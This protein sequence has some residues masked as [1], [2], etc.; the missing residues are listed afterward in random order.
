M[1]R[2][3]RR[4]RTGALIAGRD[5]RTARAKVLESISNAYVM[6]SIAAAVQSYLNGLTA[7]QHHLAPPMTA[8][9]QNFEVKAPTAHC[10]SPPFPASS[11]THTSGPRQRPISECL[12]PRHAGGS[13]P[14]LRSFK[15]I[16]VRKHDSL[17]VVPRPRLYPQE[18]FVPT[19]PSA[20]CE[21]AKLHA[22]RVSW[23]ITDRDVNGLLLAV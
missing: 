15:R 14:T 3:P 22:S 2:E 5:E 16:C 9:P 4:R 18:Y 19:I 20:P 13:A 8:P 12:P 10:T 11:F 23:R 6:L 17:R 1:A 7:P 21:R